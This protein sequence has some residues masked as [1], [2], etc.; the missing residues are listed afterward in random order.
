[1]PHEEVLAEII[2]L[3][4]AAGKLVAET[5]KIPAAVA[6]LRLVFQENPNNVS[7]KEYGA[8]SKAFG[9]VL[10]ARERFD[11]ELANFNAEFSNEAPISNEGPIGTKEA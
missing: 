7:T 1:M 3:T 8:I 6:R 11:E 10:D 4:N 9:E 5:Q 2:R